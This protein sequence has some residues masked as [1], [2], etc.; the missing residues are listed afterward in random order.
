[1]RISTQQIFNRSVDALLN[2]QREISKTSEQLATGRK[3]V[4]PSDDPSGSSRALRLTESINALESFALIR[5][6]A[7]DSLNQ[8][9]SI[10]GRM[11]DIVSEIRT[12]IVQ[13]GNEPLDPQSKR[14]IANKIESLVDSLAGLA[15]STD[16]NGAFLFA[17]YLNDAPAYTKNADGVYEYQGDDNVRIEQVDTGRDLRI[18]ETGPNIFNSFSDGRQYQVQADPDNTGSLSY[19]EFRIRDREDPNYGDQFTVEFADNAGVLEF[20]VDGGPPQAYNSDITQIEY[21]GVS[22]TISGVAADGDTFTVG[23]AKDIQT[24]AFSSLAGIV[25][26]LR[27]DVEV[28]NGEAQYENTIQ[29]GLRQVDQIFE[30]LL[31]VRSRMGVNL[32][33]LD[34]LDTVNESRLLSLKQ[35]KSAI[36]DLN[37][38]EAVSE[39]TQQQTAIDAAQKAFIRVAGLSL[40]NQL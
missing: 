27:S 24:D 21:N 25:E 29:T 4:N 32:A 35:S 23:Q 10:L 17:G 31:A 22:F 2:Q 3:I 39:F 13:A 12:S 16:G 28:P 33:E 9:Q 18:G 6:N 11:G 26:G 30:N 36:I 34:T 40:F 38:V 1:M 14:G 7:R 5:N 19:S 37:F 8:Q 15:N 20:S